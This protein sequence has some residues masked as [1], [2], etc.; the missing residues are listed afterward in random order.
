MKP[1]EWRYD[2]EAGTAP[3]GQR[4]RQLQSERRLA[5][6]RRPGDP[7]EEPFSFRVDRREQLTGQA[8]SITHARLDA[9]RRGP[10]V[11]AAV[12]RVAFDLG[13]LCVR[14]VQPVEGGHVGLELL[15]P[16]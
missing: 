11:E 2:D 6:A 9:A 14:E 7:E 10:E 1:V 4:R 5:R 15:D 8:S 3:L 12:G 13:E 16:A